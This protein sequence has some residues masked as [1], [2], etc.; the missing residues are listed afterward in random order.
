VKDT[1]FNFISPK[2]VITLEIFDAIVSRDKLIDSSSTN[3]TK[4]LLGIFPALG[5]SDF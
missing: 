5:S 1:I 3:V 4:I 2:E